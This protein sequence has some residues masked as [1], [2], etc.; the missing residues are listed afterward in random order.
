MVGCWCTI[1]VVCMCVLIHP[2]YDLVVKYMNFGFASVGC[3][4]LITLPTSFS[5]AQYFLLYINV[6]FEGQFSST[7]V[8][9]DIFHGDEE[10]KRS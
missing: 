8:G 5:I 1:S 4:S 2:A 3:P 6:I 7:F 9:R 10:V